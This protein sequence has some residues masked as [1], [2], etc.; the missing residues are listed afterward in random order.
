MR[1]TKLQTSPCPTC[2]GETIPQTGDDGLPATELCLKC[3]GFTIQPNEVVQLTNKMIV[4]V[5]SC[6]VQAPLFDEFPESSEPGPEQ[7]LAMATLDMS[8]RI[9]NVIKSKSLP[10]IQEYSLF[11]LE[12]QKDIRQIYLQLARESYD[13]S[14]D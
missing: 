1:K 10:T 3:S 2:G 13:P 9:R 7:R 14:S 11:R 5:P 8:K 12:C 6:E 4:D